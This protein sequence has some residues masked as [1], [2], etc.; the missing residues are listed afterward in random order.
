MANAAFEQGQFRSNLAA[1]N[2][3]KVNKDT[4]RNRRNGM[5]PRRDC[6]PNSKKL[7]EL[8]ERSIIDHALDV[9]TRGFQLN[10]DMLRDIADKLLQDRG[11][12]RV[13]VNWP[14]RFVLRVPELRLRVNRRYDYQRSLNENPKVIED[15]FR[16]VRNTKA[17]YGILD[18]DTYNFDETGFKMGVIG[19][20][21]VITGTERRQAPKSIQPGNT[22]WV[23][24]IVAASAAGWPVPPFIIFKGA[25]YFDTWYQALADRPQ[26]VLSVSEKGWTSVDHG[27]MWLKHFD[28]HT[29]GLHGSHK[30]HAI[31]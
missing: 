17:K 1:A 9:D 22:E 6:T 3:Y 12:P 31:T 11:Q 10:L 13:G 14:N 27:F 25:R 7:T 2:A 20:R 24:A 23:T 19:S 15:W 18:E 21:I 29:E 26:W 8:E 4:L 16:L 30:H 28:K 5:R